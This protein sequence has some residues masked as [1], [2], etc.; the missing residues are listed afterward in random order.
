MSSNRRD[1]LIFPVAFVVLIVW[2]AS[3][4]VGALTGAYTALTITTG[5]M[6]ALA[7]YVFGVN[8]VRKDKSD[9]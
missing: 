4:I 6:L 5:P 3:F 9:G 8:L 2:A 7:G 1:A